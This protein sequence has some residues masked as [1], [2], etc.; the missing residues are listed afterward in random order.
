MSIDY[1]TEIKL[2]VMHNLDLDA[3]DTDAEARFQILES[4]NAAQRIVIEVAPLDRIDNIVKNLAG[5]LVINTANYSW[6]SDYVRFIG[7]WIDY[8][9]AITDSNLGRAV[10]RKKNGDFTIK[11]LDRS[12]DRQNP[13]WAPINN[14]FELRPM[15][16]V[17]LTDGY[18]LRFVY[19][20][21]AI[22][23]S[24]T[25]PF[26]SDLKNALI[27][28]ATELAALKGGNRVEQANKYGELFRGEFITSANAKAT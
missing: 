17:T 20:P 25:S 14:G 27:F 13:K 2:E 15:P 24:Q 8:T 18:L 4:A 23:A 10:T 16:S 11:S 21:P 5:Q 6:P 22:S 28:K 7:L 12:H 1:N 9:N 3:T 26:R 19:N